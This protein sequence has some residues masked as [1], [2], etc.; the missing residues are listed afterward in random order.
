[1]AEKTSQ[2]SS[3]LLVSLARDAIKS[4]VSEGRIIDA[5]PSQSELGSSAACFVFYSSKIDG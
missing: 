3:D 1:M 5:D 4:Y 2:A